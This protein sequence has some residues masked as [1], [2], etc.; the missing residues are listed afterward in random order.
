MNRAEESR[1]QKQA[2]KATRNQDQKEDSGSEVQGLLQKAVPLHQAGQWQEAKNLYRNILAIE[3]GHADA[4]HL[5]GLIARQSGN[6]E[7]AV[8][9]ISEAIRENP[10]EAAYHNNLGN[11][12]KDLGR[13]DDAVESYHAALAIN[14]D[15]A[16]AHSNLGAALK[17]QGRLEDAVASLRKA[18]ELNPDLANAHVN[19]GNVLK[20]QGRME[21]AVASYRK[22]IALNPDEAK[23][24]G[25]LGLALQRMGRLQD[26]VDCHDRAVDLD[27]ENAE[28]HAALGL[29]LHEM[30]RPE[31]AL[32]SYDKAITLNYDYAEVHN[33]RGNT[34]RELGRLDDAIACYHKAIELKPEYSEAHS[35]LGHL[36]LLMGDYRNGWE[37]CNWRWRVDEFTSVERQPGKPQWDGAPIGGKRLLVWSEQ[38]IGDEVLFA[39]MVPD[40][41]ERG[42][43]V[44]LEC[45][46]RLV[47]LFARSFPGVTC[48]AKDG[49]NPAFDFHIPSGG[50]GRVLRPSLGSFPEPAPY[51]VADP[52]LRTEF[53]DRYHDQGTGALVGLAWHSKSLFDGKESQLTLSGLRPTLETSGVIFIDLQYGDTSEEREAFLK[54]TGIEIIHDNQVDQ[55][56]DL[57]AFAAQI[58]AMDLVLSIDNS[59]VHIAGALG[60]P[61]WAMLRT[62]PYWC[63]GL[64]RDDSLWYPSI[65]LF[66]QKTREDWR[67]VMERVARELAG[68]SS[69][70]E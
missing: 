44:I 32:A 45:D 29:A 59:T 62:V 46:P 53:C 67:D 37:G 41:I 26:A 54:K 66:R 36:Q 1:R 51:L 65:R 23:A 13:L 48:I 61:T 21:D 12:L 9:L 19:L 58:A 40:L 14:P 25:N 55:M 39:G 60:V 16:A 52:E 28:A 42:I 57:D 15:F 11:A 24:H 2:K 7:A 8:K 31:D 18:I 56:V 34:L 4:H 69:L 22:A 20:D 30:D 70:N 68:G 38:G 50:L 10:C 43:D 33:N 17:G 64:D 6:N 63:W 35:N 27:P 47:P 5:L 49:A 3:P